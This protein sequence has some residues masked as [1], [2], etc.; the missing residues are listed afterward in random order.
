MIITI[1]ASLKFISQI[2]EV[3]SILEKKGHSVLVPLSAEINQDKEY[4]NHLKSNN[5]EKFASIKGGRMKG[6]FDK[7]KSS[8]A[9][10]VL[11][12]DKHGNKN[13]IGANTLIEMGIAFEH[14]KKIFVL[15][16]LPEDSPAYEELVSM[17]PVCLDG[18][19]DRI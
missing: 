15:N 19:L 18:E 11:N 12:Y 17:S 6:H 16:N 13:Y 5:I 4:W 3:K 8:D 9:I 7:I 10:L 14:G 1:C 2:N